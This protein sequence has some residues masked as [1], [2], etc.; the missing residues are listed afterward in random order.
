MK[1]VLLLASV[2]AI[3]GCSDTLAA[4]VGAIDQKESPKDL[5]AP[6]DGEKVDSVGLRA[7]ITAAIGRDDKRHVYFLVTPL[8]NKDTQ[9]HFWV[10][11]E[12]S[13]S[14]KSASGSA[15]FG[16]SSQGEGE[17]FAIIAIATDKKLTVGER[18]IGLPTGDNVTYSK[19]KIVKR[20]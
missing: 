14:N 12:V 1:N 13:R 17:Y 2:L 7:D 11:E 19:P 3:T 16:E 9:N 15:Q 18:L 4:D 5:S 8:S 6:K 10:Q 20:K